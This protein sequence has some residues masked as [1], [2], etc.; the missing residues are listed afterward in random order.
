M[1]NKLYRYLKMNNITVARAAKDLGVTRQLLYYHMRGNPLGKKTAR[2][3][4]SW[5]DGFLNAGDLIDL[6]G[7]KEGR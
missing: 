5:S 4:E 1:N 3:I 7:E 2:K 6:Y